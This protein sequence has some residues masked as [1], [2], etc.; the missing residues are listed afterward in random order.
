MRAC[1][2]SRGSQR[3]TRSSAW[4]GMVCVLG[5]MACAER[6]LDE[7]ASRDPLEHTS[8]C[9]GDADGRGER[10]GGG[11]DIGR[12][13]RSPRSHRSP[14]NARREVLIEKVE[15]IDP[16]L[17][18]ADTREALWVRARA[19]ESMELVVSPHRPRRIIL[20]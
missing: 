12:Q 18:G 6:M 2:V 13:R 7:R 1:I 10:G 8:A 5:G 4:T 20:L 9:E 15:G 19:A 11:L 17:M 3:Q 16:S 14:W